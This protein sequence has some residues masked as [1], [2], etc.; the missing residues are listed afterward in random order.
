MKAIVIGEA[1]VQER[2]IGDDGAGSDHD[3]IY[4]GAEAMGVIS[5]LGSG[6]PL[7]GSV[8]G[9]H[10]TVEGGGELQCDL[11]EASTPMMEIG[12]IHFFTGSNVDHHLY[13]CRLQ[14]GDP[15]SLNSG[16]RIQG[17]YHHPGD[18]SAEESIDARRGLPVVRA[19]LESHYHRASP[20]PVTGLAQ[21]GN[22]GVGRAGS[23]V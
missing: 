18:S 4:L 17:P 19:R 15:A 14:S 20:G 3:R 5:G 1:D 12:G 16:I 10:L 2:V 21:G 7:R 23:W 22:L 6:D 8:L 13:A 11:R 9:G